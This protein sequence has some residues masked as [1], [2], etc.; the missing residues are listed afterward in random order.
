[1]DSS[2][3]RRR[4]LAPRRLEPLPARRAIG[5]GVAESARS[6]PMSAGLSYLIIKPAHPDYARI[7]VGIWRPFE[8]DQGMMK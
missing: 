8:S 2:A 7:A 3:L 6:L 5:R 4:R 1:M